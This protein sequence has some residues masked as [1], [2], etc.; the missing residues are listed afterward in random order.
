[1]R[2]AGDTRRFD[3]THLLQEAR[4]GNSSAMD[5]LMSALYADLR[6]IVRGVMASEGQRHAL[7]PAAVVGEAFLRFVPAR[8]R[9]P[10]LHPEAPADWQSRA[11][12]L[13]IAARQMRLVLS[14]NA[15]G[16]GR[17][18]AFLKIALNDPLLD[19]AAGTR[20]FAALDELLR[21]S[22]ETD[23]LRTRI[24]EMH[25]FAAMSDR[26]IA[27]VEHTSTSKA[28]RDRE[29]ARNWLAGMM[30]SQS[31]YN[32]QPKSDNESL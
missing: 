24:L 4:N 25:C 7:E 2:D 20:D 14:D 15:T 10:A 31:L 12:F 26:E 17:S 32:T 16:R 29:L 27:L 30:A 19:G 5:R 6:R 21:L 8:R 28:K 18:N 11:H 22:S 23:S 13:A 9:S 1:M 3:I